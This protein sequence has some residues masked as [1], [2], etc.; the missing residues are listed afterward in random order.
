MT[1]WLQLGGELGKPHYA[2]FFTKMQAAFPYF[3][4]GTHRVLILSA[5]ALHPAEVLQNLT[6][7]TPDSAAWKVEPNNIEAQHEFFTRAVMLRIDAFS[8]PTTATAPESAV[9]TSL[10]RL[11][12]A[13]SETDVEQVSATPAPAATTP[14]SASATAAAPASAARRRAADATALVAKRQK[15]SEAHHEVCPWCQN[16]KV[17]VDAGWEVRYCAECNAS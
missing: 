10:K 3:S 12:T 1:Q 17:L 9:D 7:T 5:L 6:A 16:A 14:S 4:V 11:L 13:D 8:T 2:T 15:P